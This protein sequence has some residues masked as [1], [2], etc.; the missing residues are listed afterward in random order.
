[1]DVSIGSIVTDWLGGHGA[2]ILII[3]LISVAL[4]FVLH[5]FLPRVVK[6][7]VA[8]K[9]KKKP[10]TEI[11]KRATTLSR[12]LVATG[13]V[14]IAVAA[15]F[16]ILS[17]VGINITPVVAGFGIAGI[18]VGF[19]AQSLV[20]DVI[21]G[22]FILIENQYGVGDVARI[23]DITGIV[24][25]VNLRRTILRDLDGIVHSVP[26]GEIKVVPRESEYL[27]G[28]RRGPRP[29]N[30]GFKQDRPGDCQRPRMGASHH[31]SASCAQG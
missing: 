14:L 7:H 2:R 22:F 24:E 28:L 18:A 12:V 6:L 19:G 27:S 21:A 9:M 3:V 5:H 11:E 23:A 17:E 13:I 8:G 10:P 20:K 4:Y 1:M 15:L 16:M 31:G 30:R 25:E 26:N 29:R